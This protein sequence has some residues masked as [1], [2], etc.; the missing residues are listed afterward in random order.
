MKYRIT[1]ELDDAE[2]N[3]ENITELSFR[4]IPLL[5]GSFA[6]DIPYY[7]VDRNAEEFV[8]LPS[9]SWLLATI[10]RSLEVAQVNFDAV[11]NESG[12]ME[13]AKEQLLGV[14]NLISRHRTILRVIAKK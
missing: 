7:N 10:E 1:F 11:R 4:A 5:D 13:Y 3:K 8:A 6:F 12:A 9:V 14:L 2:L